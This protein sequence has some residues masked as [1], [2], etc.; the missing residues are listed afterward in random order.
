MP[1]D[2]GSARPAT[3]LGFADTQA[4]TRPDFD[5][6][7]GLEKPP[8][9]EPASESEFV[10]VRRE[11]YRKGVSLRRA[12][13]RIGPGSRLRTERF[14]EILGGLQLGVPPESVD[15]I[16]A[17]LDG[18]KTGSID[19]S[20]FIDA[21]NIKVQPRSPQAE[22]LQGAPRNSLSRSLWPRLPPPASLGARLAWAAEQRSAAPASLLAFQVASGCHRRLAPHRRFDV[23]RT[24]Q[25]AASAAARAACAYLRCMRRDPG[26]TRIRA[27]GRCI[28]HG[29]RRVG[30]PLTPTPKP[31]LGAM[32]LFSLLRFRIGQSWRQILA[33][34]RQRAG[35]RGGRTFHA[36]AA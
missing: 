13:G 10:A 30:L 9:P 34:R 36:N 15:R 8:R 12:F 26:V 19:L 32:K 21:L 11:I 22:L 7:M 28:P 35:D 3:S 23:A 17:S 24:P 20:R 33:A 5:A 1:N 29:R 31:E 4:R 2:D 25:H 27:A 18:D 16:V 14:R 6:V